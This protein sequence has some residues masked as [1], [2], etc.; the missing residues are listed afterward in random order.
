MFFLS[1]LLGL[2]TEPAFW[3]LLLLL[4]ALVQLPRSPQSAR[5]WI[6]AATALLLL[7]GWAPLPD[8][9]LRHLERQYPNPPA[10][11]VQQYAGVIVLGGA[12]ESAYVFE[13]TQEPQVNGAAERMTTVLPLL[14]QAPDLEVV[15]TGGEGEYFGNGLSEAERTRRFFVQLGLDPQRVRLEDRSRN[16]Y[17]NAVFTARLSGIDPQKPWILITSASH[18]PRA[19][20]VFKK[21]GWNVTPYSVDFRAGLATPWPTYSLGEFE[22]WH[23]AL[24]EYLGLLA[25]RL[26]G[27]I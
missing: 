2:A 11:P 1:K 20:A 19:L 13:G 8:A 9:L 3:I 25:Y 16:T 7:A 5:R 17:E 21:Q 26:S 18:M 23:V 27:R 14:R 6:L 15:F 4:L 10:P 12:T 22:K 24:H